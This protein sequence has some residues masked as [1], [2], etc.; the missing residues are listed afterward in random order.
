MQTLKG[1][2]PYVPPQN[3]HVSVV[4]HFLAGQGWGTRVWFV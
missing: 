4:V 3:V 2:L 1:I